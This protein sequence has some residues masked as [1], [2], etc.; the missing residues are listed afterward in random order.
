MESVSTGRRLTPGANQMI[1]LGYAGKTLESKE[2][3]ASKEIRVTHNSVFAAHRLQ[4]R[5]TIHKVDIRHFV[6][7]TGILP[8]ARYD[9]ILDTF[10]S[11][12]V[13]ARSDS[14][15]RTSTRFS[16]CT[17]AAWPDSHQGHRCR[18]R[19]SC[20]VPPDRTHCR[21]SHGQPDRVARRVG[22]AEYIWRQTPRFPSAALRC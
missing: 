6:C 5:M 12:F 22:H 13:S 21:R 7:S 18:R 1:V 14:N 17:R 3:R 11:A 20:P 9:L 2:T 19:D 8:L 16:R 10:G 15:R 4:C